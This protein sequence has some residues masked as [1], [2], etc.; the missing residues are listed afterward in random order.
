MKDVFCK[1]K[2]VHVLCLELEKK[3]E[4]IL[5]TTLMSWFTC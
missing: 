4:I 2:K 1:Q 5:K 3:T